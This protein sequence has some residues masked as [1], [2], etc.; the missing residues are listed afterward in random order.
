MGSVTV[1]AGDCI[2]SIAADA[3]F[4]WETIWNHPQ[5]AALKNKRK[6]PGILFPGDVV[7]VPEIQVRKESRASEKNYIFVKK[8]NTVTLS[9]RLVNEFHARSNL[10]YTL[11]VGTSQFKGV[12]DGN[13]ELKAKI[14]ASATEAVLKTAEDSYT[15]AIGSLAPIDENLG[16]QQRLQNLG[17]LGDDTPGQITDATTAAIMK[18]QSDQKLKDDGTLTDATRN[19]LKE[20]H[21]C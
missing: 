1:Q 6:D 14:P 17:Y 5:N 13:G 7:F 19:K 9:L 21:G 18:F 11:Q 3:G 2:S 15:I 12:T 10:K 8:N 4:Y 16:V 20:L